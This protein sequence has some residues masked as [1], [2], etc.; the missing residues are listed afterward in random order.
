MTPRTLHLAIVALLSAFAATLVLLTWR[1][2]PPASIEAAAVPA[3]SDA[4]RREEPLSPLPRNA[5]NGDPERI[6]LGERLFNER[7]LSRDG[8]ISCASC[9]P[10]ERGGADGLAHSP[11]VDNALG[12]INTPTVFNTVYNF[13]QFWDG[14]ALTLED[15]VAGPIHNPLEMDSNWDEVIAR[16]NADA[17]Y[18][19]SFARLYPRGITAETISDAIAAFERTLTTPD[20]RFDQYLRGD[21]GILS[22]EEKQGYVLFKNLG[23]TSCH[24]GVNVGGNLFQRF[25]VMGDYFA[26][27]GSITRAD[28]GRYNVT[29]EEHDR[30]VFKVPSLR[31]VALTAP[32]FHDGSVERLES[33]VEIMAR[34][35]LGRQLSNEDIQLVVAFLRTLTG[36]YQGQALQ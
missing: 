10:L 7:M 25:G 17:G 21:H 35:Q 15:Q 31:N 14:R 13:A 26:D 24:Q 36:T 6:A 9:H 12:E 28:L 19:A 1:E 23:C 22:P 18:R 5:P 16:L 33:A 2:T 3:I 34:Y 30:H 32:Y 4:I 11:G 27:R 8:S 20:A 29:G